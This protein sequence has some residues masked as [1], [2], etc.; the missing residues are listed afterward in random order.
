MIK[1]SQSIQIFMMVL[2]VNEYYSV[3][4]DDV[5]IDKKTKTNMFFLNV[6][7]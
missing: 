3:F 7:Y 1:E 6:F 4:Y 2:V 5:I